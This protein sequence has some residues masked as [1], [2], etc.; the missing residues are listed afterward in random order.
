MRS[1]TESR[2]IRSRSSSFERSIQPLGRGRWWGRGAPGMDEVYR[3]LP[4]R[5]HRAPDP[6]RVSAPVL[7]RDLRNSPH[8][9]S[10]VRATPLPSTHI[11]WLRVTASLPPGGDAGSRSSLMPASTCRPL[12][13]QALRLSDQR[14]RLWSRQGG[15]CWHGFLKPCSDV[16]APRGRL[17]GGTVRPLAIHSSIS[18]SC[19][20]RASGLPHGPQQYS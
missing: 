16:E 20:A 3:D 11:A 7:I 9:V 10:S 5:P 14:R 6:F 4:I 18:R 19:S 17:W 8:G 1:A 12:P 13:R 2:E 15:S